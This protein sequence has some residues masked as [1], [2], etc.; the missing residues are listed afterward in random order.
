M[1]T[2]LSL[3][4]LLIQRL[5]ASLDNFEILVTHDDY[6]EILYRDE[7]EDDIYDGRKTEVEEKLNCL[8]LSK[9]YVKMYYFRLKALEE[10]LINKD[11]CQCEK[12]LM[13]AVEVSLDG[14]GE[15]EFSNLLLSEIEIENI[16]A[17]TKVRYLNGEEYKTV[18]EK[19]FRYYNYIMMHF[20][21]EEE[22]S[23]LL[24]KCTWLI[25][26]VLND[27]KFYEEAAYYCLK[28]IDLLGKWNQF[29]F[30]EPLLE[31]MGRAYTGMGV[32]DDDNVW[33]QSFET[34]SVF[35]SELGIRTYPKDIVIRNYSLKELILDSDVVS[36]LRKNKK[37][38]QEH[39]A[40]GI[41]SSAKPISDFERGKTSL[42]RK[43][44]VKVLQKLDANK[45]VWNSYYSYSSYELQKKKVNLNL[46]YSK[47]NF[48][49]IDRILIQMKEEIGHGRFEDDPELSVLW[50]I[51]KAQLKKGDVDNLLDREEKLLGDFID[52]DKTTDKRV[53]FFIDMF[54]L[55]DYVNHLSQK[56][57]EMTVS[58]LLTNMMSTIEGC[59]GKERYRYRTYGTLYNKLLTLTETK[60]DA[61][62]A[63]KM[64]ISHGKAC[65][66]LT[67]ILYFIRNSEKSNDVEKVVLFSKAMYYYSYLYFFEYA[68]EVYYT[69]LHNELNV[70]LQHFERNPNRFL[71]DLD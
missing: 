3:M 68:Y 25:T 24:A 44:L 66:F 5:G 41:F 36:H 43:N 53:P 32:S 27:N 26:I 47:K 17:L 39:L 30:M 58:H 35:E 9:Q 7:I 69:F 23:K 16:I 6:S 34:F 21:E 50:E 33:K 4:E 20:E 45:H 38:T 67:E 49:E 31:Q 10:Y 62:R 51:V 65:G 29:Y 2:S 56:G 60:E 22:R 1:E 11:F 59:M 61:L 52:I 18:L 70:N 28:A 8:D 57:E 42:T 14:E 12:M 37:I 71:L 15:K 19:A 64:D 48:E 46:L 54:V 40:E 63:F 55:K 13:M